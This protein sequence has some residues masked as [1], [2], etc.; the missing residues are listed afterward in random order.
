[1]DTPHTHKTEQ[2]KPDTGETTVHVSDDVKFKKQENAWCWN[3]EVRV[4]TERSMR[5]SRVHFLIYTP[6]IHIGSFCVT[7]PS[8]TLLIFVFF[9]RN[10]TLTKKSTQ[11]L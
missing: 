1:M 5:I 7:S 3:L 9:C 10:V 2:Q 4:M 11:H 8:C 6:I